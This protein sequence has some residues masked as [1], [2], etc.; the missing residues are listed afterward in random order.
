M[1][2]AMHDARRRGWRRET[3]VSEVSQLGYS[4]VSGGGVGA[5]CCAVSLS[6]DEEESS[7]LEVR[8]WS[9]RAGRETPPSAGLGK[10]KLVLALGRLVGDSTFE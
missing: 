3:G 6:G 2:Y 8:T 7:W 5:L 9:W 4:I 10:H 1:Q